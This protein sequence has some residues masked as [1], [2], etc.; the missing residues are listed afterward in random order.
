MTLLSEVKKKHPQ[1]LVLIQSG[2]FYEAAGIDAVIL[3]EY[4]LRPM[5]EDNCPRAGFPKTSLNKYLRMFVNKAHM[6]V[7]AS[8]GLWDSVGQQE[9]T[10]LAVEAVQNWEGLRAF[11]SALIKLATQQRGARDDISVFL[12]R[13]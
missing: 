1:W 10:A 13:L 4:G 11:G 3:V 6:I 12:A 5:G 8:D 9:V 2:S 7:M